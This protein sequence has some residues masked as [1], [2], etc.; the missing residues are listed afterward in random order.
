MTISVE[1]LFI[2]LVRNKMQNKF[3][4]IGPF[5][6]LPAILQEVQKHWGERAAGHGVHI[7]M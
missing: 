6:V 1:K 5:K 7:V 4:I 3:G 2:S